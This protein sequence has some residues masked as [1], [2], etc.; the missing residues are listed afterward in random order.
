[1]SAPHGIAPHGAAKPLMSLRYQASTPLI[2]NQRGSGGVPLI[3]Q[4]RPGLDQAAA[5]AMRPAQ[6]S[7]T[8]ARGQGLPRKGG[9]PPI[10][11][12]AFSHRLPFLH[13]PEAGGGRGDR[14]RVDVVLRGAGP[15]YGD[16]A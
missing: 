7:A 6:G 2:E 14:A 5:A 11:G 15:G 16:M 9:R 8:M 1:M 13:L 10:Q 12:Q 3:W 4:G